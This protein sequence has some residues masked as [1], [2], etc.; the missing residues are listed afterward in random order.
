[1]PVKS[2]QDLVQKVVLT[3]QVMELR[4]NLAGPPTI[5]TVIE[6]L[7]SFT[8]DV[9]NL[10]ELSSYIYVSIPQL[11][12]GAKSKLLLQLLQ[13]VVAYLL[14]AKTEQQVAEVLAK[15]SKEQGILSEELPPPRSH[16][17]SF[18]EL[19]ND[20]TS[21][22]TDDRL[23][24]EDCR[25]LLIEIIDFLCNNNP[26]L[27]PY[28]AELRQKLHKNLNQAKVPAE[29]RGW[30]AM[31][32]QKDLRLQEHTISEAIKLLESI[33]SVVETSDTAE[34]AL[35]TSVLPPTIDNFFE[36]IQREQ[37]LT[38]YDLS[39][40]A[41]DASTAIVQS[42]KNQV[43]RMI[44]RGMASEWIELLKS[45]LLPIQQT[46]TQRQNELEQTVAAAELEVARD[47]VLRQKKGAREITSV[48]R[49]EEDIEQPRSATVL[50]AIIVTESDTA[51]VSYSE[52]EQV[53]A[54]L[55]SLREEN[56]KLKEESQQLKETMLGEQE[57]LVRLR[58]LLQTHYVVLP[59][60]LPAKVPPEMG[61]SFI[62]QKV[63]DRLVELRLSDTTLSQRYETLLKEG[64]Q[65]NWNDANWSSLAPV[66]LRLLKMR[67]IFAD[68]YSPLF[69]SDPLSTYTEDV[70][71][72]I[73][74]EKQVIVLFDTV[75][76][77]CRDAQGILNTL[78]KTPSKDPHLQ[79]GEMVFQ[80][81]V[82]FKKLCADCVDEL[83][84]RFENVMGRGFVKTLL[85]EG[86][87][88][89][90]FVETFGPFAR[91]NIPIIDA[92]VEKKLRKATLGGMGIPT[93]AVDSAT[94]SPAQL[95]FLA[96]TRD[97]LL[98][99]TPVA[100]GAA[101]ASVPSARNSGLNT[102]STVFSTPVATPSSS[103]AVYV[104]DDESEDDFGD[105]SFA[106]PY[107]SDPE[108]GDVQG[109]MRASLANRFPQ[110]PRK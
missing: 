28:T 81:K 80:K 90:K 34:D 46:L 9:D 49:A 41:Q 58:E 36:I 44:D 73:S 99:V 110:S 88:Y 7:K 86:E 87:D 91:R 26:I 56:A 84:K 104:A 106:E 57:E 18:R 4:R 45:Q 55:V 27:S 85:G 33:V 3:Y 61:Y 50:P 17:L 82:E 31:D 98:A 69:Q 15:L 6:G 67:K 32:E 14:K 60:D 101:A 68:L 19:M 51:S 108:E 12:D 107:D 48:L 76:I 35:S 29:M 70:K 39:E 11:K 95:E 30:V 79:V 13:L 20:V 38:E 53:K 105:T 42:E 22:P 52:L 54:E 24:T 103:S 92:I 66:Y 75:S 97:S 93:G 40:D 65:I 77:T 102:S 2:I 23:F 100:T 1:M 89:I 8:V 59:A 10:S 21:R 71:Y 16:R 72:F 25:V 74:Q 63:T 109:L 64:S 47:A 96:S 43:L 62:T 83:S 78:K 94:N 5:N 37:Q